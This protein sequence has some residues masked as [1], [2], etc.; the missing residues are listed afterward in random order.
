[1]GPL[2]AFWGCGGSG[3][4]LSLTVELGVAGTAASGTVWLVD[5]GSF[6]DSVAIFY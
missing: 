5:G 4:H 6:R 1:M 3:V 2:L